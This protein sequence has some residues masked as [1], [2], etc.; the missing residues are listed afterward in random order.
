MCLANGYTKSVETCRA[1][2]IS[3]IA[4]HHCKNKQKQIPHAVVYTLQ[5]T[6]WPVPISHIQTEW[7]FFVSTLLLE[8]LAIFLSQDK[9]KNAFL[10]RGFLPSDAA[11]LV[12][13]IDYANNANIFTLLSERNLV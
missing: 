4:K 13:K 2:R 9:A 1:Y 8:I 10:T 3:G 11:K 6:A 12:Q 5:G 7:R